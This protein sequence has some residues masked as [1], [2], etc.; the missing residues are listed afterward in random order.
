MVTDIAFAPLPES[1][2]G[3]FV[4]L[5]LRR[6]QAISVVHLALVLDFAA[7]G[8]VKVPPSPR[9]AWPPP[10]FTPRRP[11]RTWWARR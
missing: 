11:R 1:A 7:D 2:R 9:A 6:A 5:G 3:I 8:T 10:S 4:K